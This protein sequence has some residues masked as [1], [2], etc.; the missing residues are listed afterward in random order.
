MRNNQSKHNLNKLI[1]KLKVLE[2]ESHHLKLKLLNQLKLGPQH[3][4]PPQQLKQRLILVHKQQLP[5]Q[6]QHKLL[7]QDQ[8]QLQI[9]E[10]EDQPHLLLQVVVVEDWKKLRT[11]IHFWT[12]MLTF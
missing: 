11:Q 4:L 12:T 10:Q 5:V 6:G 8:L 2:L 1:H 9:K 3:K 7:Q